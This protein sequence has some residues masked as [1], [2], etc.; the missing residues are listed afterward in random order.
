[1]WLNG[2]YV[3]LKV[4]KQRQQHVGVIHLRVVLAGSHDAIGHGQRRFVGAPGTPVTSKPVVPR[5]I[6]VCV[7]SC[8][9]HA[10]G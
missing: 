4:V 8:N 7:V 2:R 6:A 9:T 3:R 10:T 1:M 5:A